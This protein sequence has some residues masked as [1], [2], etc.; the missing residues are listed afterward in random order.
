M[1]DLCFSTLVDESIEVAGCS[2]NLHR[3]TALYRVHMPTHAQSTASWPLLSWYSPDETTFCAS[4]SLAIAA[5]TC[6]ASPPRWA[7]RLYPIGK[8]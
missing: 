5:G 2:R 3:D 8:M 6:L 7:P 4:H 1:T